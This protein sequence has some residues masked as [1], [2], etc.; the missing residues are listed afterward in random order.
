MAEV[1]F[2]PVE[3]VEVYFVADGSIADTDAPTSTELNTGTRITDFLTDGPPNPAGSTFIDAGTLASGFATQVASTYGG[4][5]GQMTV[6]V[7]R[8][9]TTTDDT[10]DTAYNLFPRGT[11]GHL[12]VAPYGVGGTANDF[13]SGDTITLLPIEVGNRQRNISRGS[14]H[15]ATIEVAFNGLP[16]ENYDLAS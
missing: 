12:A 16:N 6:I 8:D 1:P 11:V 4:G 10:A 3:I 7:K 2:D 13:A 5:S 14:L 15:T 9:T